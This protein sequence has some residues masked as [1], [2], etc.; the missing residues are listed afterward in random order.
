MSYDGNIHFVN[1]VAHNE[2]FTD[3]GVVYS[4]LYEG[5]LASMTEERLFVMIWDY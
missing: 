4:S 2:C 5:T 3:V 1:I